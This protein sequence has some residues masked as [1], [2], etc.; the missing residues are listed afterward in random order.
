[1]SRTVI[2]RPGRKFLIGGHERRCDIVCQEEAIC[3]N[4][5]EL[6]DIVVTDDTTTACLR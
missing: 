4:V 2:L 6:N 3:V 5:E 1:M